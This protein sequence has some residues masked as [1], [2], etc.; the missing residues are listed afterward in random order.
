MRLSEFCDTVVLGL[1]ALIQ[2]DIINPDF[3]WR[4]DDKTK[5]YKITV[6]DI[7]REAFDSAPIVSTSGRI[8][9]RLTPG[10]S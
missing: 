9:V 2:G 3:P 1:R 5:I 10:V 7:E 6:A 8:A 4:L